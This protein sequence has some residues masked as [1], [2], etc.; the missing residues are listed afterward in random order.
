[1]AALLI[2][3]AVATTL[4]QKAGPHEAEFR[5]FYADFLKAVAANDKEKIADMIK[6][7]VASDWSVDTRGNIQT[8]SID[9][10]ADFIKRYNVLFTPYMRLHAAKAKPQALDGG[11]YML[12]WKNQDVECS[13]EFEYI[14]G[15]GYRLT[16]YSIGP[17]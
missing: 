6:F 1:M 15:T 2:A 13:F 8:V 3:I 16:A 17:L 10:R 9:D 11:R 4:A 5:A 7:P 12:G 14:D